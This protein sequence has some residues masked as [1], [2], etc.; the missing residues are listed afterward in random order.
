MNF[1]QKQP[2]C[3]ENTILELAGK[4]TKAEFEF[5]FL[6]WREKVRNLFIWLKELHGIYDCGICLG[7]KG[8]N[9]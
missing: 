3:L 7:C 9:R 8:H 2:V 6:D 4:L 1:F 5:Q